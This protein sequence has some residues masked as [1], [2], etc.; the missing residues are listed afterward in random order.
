LAKVGQACGTLLTTLRRRNGVKLDTI[1]SMA[2]N[3]SVW[4]GGNDGAIYKLARG[5]RQVFSPQGLEEPFTSSVLLAVNPEGEKLAVVEPAKQR[6]VILD[7]DGNYQ[8]QVNSP[9]IGGVT[10]VF[11][12]ADEKSVFLI[13]GSVVYKVDL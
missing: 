8:Q 3:G 7:K 4:L 11:L 5:E 9:Q 2:I 12:S 10:D 6:L 1:V 13:G